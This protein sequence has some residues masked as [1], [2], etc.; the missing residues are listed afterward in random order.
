MITIIFIKVYEY[1][2]RVYNL[3]YIVVNYTLSKLG[4]DGYIWISL[5]VR[6]IKKKYYLNGN[7][8]II[9]SMF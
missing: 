3:A 2:M 6:N 7:K 9:C 1:Q 4:N 8:Y 5:I